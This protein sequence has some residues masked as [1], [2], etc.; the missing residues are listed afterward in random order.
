MTL[1]K[2]FLY[3]TYK[4]GDAPKDEL[5][6]KFWN[7]LDKI[8]RKLD[9]G[10]PTEEAYDKNGNKLKDLFADLVVSIP[11]EQFNNSMIDQ[12]EIN[13]MVFMLKKIQKTFLLIYM[14]KKIIN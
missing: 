6:D 4:M 7:K 13:S 11:T 8:Y 3:D 1:I 14:I 5:Y 9:S 12:M 2:R 10:I